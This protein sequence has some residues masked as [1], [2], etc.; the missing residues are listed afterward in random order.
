[1][2]IVVPVNLTFLIRIKSAVPIQTKPT[3]TSQPKFQINRRLVPEKQAFSMQA[4]QAPDHFKS[5][6][7]MK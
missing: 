3:Q 4:L 1:M 5:K 7:M 2:V 6:G